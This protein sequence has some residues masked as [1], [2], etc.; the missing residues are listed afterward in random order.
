M[1]EHLPEVVDPI[2]LAEK[3]RRLVGHLSLGELDRLVPM[4]LCVEGQV[5]VDLRF[6]RQGR[7]SVVLGRVSTELSLECQCCLEPMA[8]SVDAQV[9]LAVVCSVDA[10]L[11]L[12]EEYEA[13]V[14]GEDR[15]VAVRDIVQDELL[16]AIP[17]IPQH[18]SCSQVPAGSE[19]PE[20]RPSPFAAL[21]DLKL[22]SFLQE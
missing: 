8:L 20:R 5:D 6:E 16:L 18:S 15:Q 4:L 7:V 21:A 3:G 11:A 22:K 10:A 13:L 12:S 14:V 19:Q 1:P 2:G 17:V 9:Q